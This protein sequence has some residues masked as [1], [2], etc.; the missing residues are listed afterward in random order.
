[1]ANT[2]KLGSINFPKLMR[3]VGYRT[4]Q[5]RDLVFARDAIFQKTVGNKKDADGSSGDGTGR[6]DAMAGPDV[7][8]GYED[9]LSTALAGTAA[10]TAYHVSSPELIL[11]GLKALQTPIVSRSGNLERTGHR[12]SGA[13]TFYMPSMG[14]IKALDNF[15]E[16]TQFSEI[17]TY[18]KLIDIE[19][20]IEHPSDI[21]ASA[22]NHP[23]TFDDK[24][25]AYEI[26]RL[27]FK[28]KSSQTLDFVMIT[29]NDG[30]TTTT[31]K[32]DGGM[33]LSSASFT[34][35]TCD[36]VN[37]D[38]TVQHNAN[39]LFV[40]GLNVFGTGI[41]AG[42]TIAS[43]TDSTHFEL[44]APATVSTHGD[45]HTLTFT[46][47][48]WITVDLPLRDI[49]DTDTT[50]VYKDGVAYTYTAAVTNSFNLDKLHG[51]DSTH[52]LVKIEFDGD[53]TSLVEI[54]DIYLYKE[55]EWRV[56]SI[57]DYRDEYMEVAAVRVRG[58]R[59]SRRRAYG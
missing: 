29:G 38:T 18:D 42:A 13:C 24:T 44:S 9:R 57:K 45:T 4:N 7:S 21:S 17:E 53:G 10:N 3:Q 15:S 54:K 46:T 59:T 41:P 31:L 51:A 16:T 1:M 37:T 40:A 32:W 12:I 50:L 49:A 39:V 8:F 14:Y 52:D 48:E 35:A 25:P 58:D 33:L 5:V 47:T 55:G 22:Q 43:I 27:Q 23:I 19:R 6:S 36:T 28:I 30:G 11:P 26:D 20:V 56:E 34:D 2:V